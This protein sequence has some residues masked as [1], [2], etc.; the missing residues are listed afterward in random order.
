MADGDVARTRVD[1][2]VPLESYAV[3]GDGRTVALVA[4]DGRI[5]WWPLP[6]MDA[7]PAF[8]AVAWS[9]WANAT[10]APVRPTN[11]AVAHNASI[12]FDDMKSPFPRHGPAPGRGAA[13]ERP[14]F[15]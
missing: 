9:A 11:A 6:T 1:G 2:Y 8:A 10:R 4:R 13:P 12:N 5:D 3:L 14:D 7:P 15:S